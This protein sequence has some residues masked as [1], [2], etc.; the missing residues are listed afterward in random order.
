MARFKSVDGEIIQLTAE[1]EAARDAEETQNAIDEANFQ[2]TTG[3]KQERFAQ[4]PPQ[5]EVI[6]ALIEAIKTMQDGGT[7]V[8]AEVVALVDSWEAA[9]LA[10][11]DPNKL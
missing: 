4:L 7:V 8:P 11:P 10:V 3:F 9:K 6:P 2:K 5:Y 1:E